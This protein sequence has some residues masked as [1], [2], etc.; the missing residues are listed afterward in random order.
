MRTFWFQRACAVSTLGVAAILVSSSHADEKPP[1]IWKVERTS[2]GRTVLSDGKLNVTFPANTRVEVNGTYGSASIKQTTGNKLEGYLSVE[3]KAAPADALT[4][5]DPQKWLDKYVR[6]QV[7]KDR[8]SVYKSQQGERKNY[9]EV[10]LLKTSAITLGEV[11][12]LKA[13]TD[14]ERALTG[15]Q[16]EGGLH[17]V[18]ET[19]YYLLGNQLYRISAGGSG[20]PKA[21]QLF[22]DHTGFH[23]SD[24]AQQFFKSAKIVK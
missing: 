5:A 15:L 20:A 21:S 11:K 2:E 18:R 9:N 16:I 13:I 8:K 10:K 3:R 17:S 6:E 19:D 12:G 23:R 22:G 1:P 24:L 4:A 7:E 14:H